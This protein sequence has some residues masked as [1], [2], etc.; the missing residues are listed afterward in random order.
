MQEYTECNR[1]PALLLLSSTYLRLHPMASIRRVGHPVIVAYLAVYATD[2]FRTS[3][4][5]GLS[6]PAG[7]VL[8]GMYTTP[9]AASCG[10]ISTLEAIHLV[11]VSQIYI[12]ET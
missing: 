10:E 4:E 8:I 5:L 9:P 12:G 11:A 1:M 6:P 7:V 3:Y 2:Y